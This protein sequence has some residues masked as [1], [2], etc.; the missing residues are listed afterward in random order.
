MRLSFFT[1]FILLVS[2]RSSAQVLEVCSVIP[3]SQPSTYR[4]QCIPSPNLTVANAGHGS[5]HGA[6]LAT[7][8]EGGFDFPFE[9]FNS[10]PLPSCLS[11]SG[12]DTNATV[13]PLSTASLAKLLVNSKVA[14][15]PT[16][17]HS[18]LVMA[19]G[20]EPL[21]RSDVIQ[22]NAQMA[23][24]L[25][26][27]PSSPVFSLELTVPHAASIPSLIER[28]RAIDPDLTVRLATRDGIVVTTAN[29]VQPACPKLTSFL[30]K[31]RD[32]AWSTHPES[33]EAR[34]P[35]LSAQTAAKVLGGSA[36][37]SASGDD[38][39]DPSEDKTPAKT[40]TAKPTKTA[41]ASP[42]PSAV[43]KSATTSKDKSAKIK[44]AA[45][46]GDV[47][48]APKKPDPGD[49][50]KAD[51]Q[52]KK[53]TDA[54][55]AAAATP[56]AATPTAVVTVG[57]IGSDLLLFTS[58]T[59]G[60]DAAIEE[61]KRIVAILNL[62]RPEM[63]ISAWSVQNSS[64]DE[65]SV[66]E[67]SRLVREDVGSYNSG[68]EK[69]LI[70][71][72]SR[73]R[74]DA[75]TTKFF[76]PSFYTYIADRV[77][78]EQGLDASPEALLREQTA[79]SSNIHKQDDERKRLGICA[80]NSYCLGYATL[81]KP[82]QPRLIDLLL[83]MIAAQSPGN[84]LR[85]SVNSAQNLPEDEISLVHTNPCSP[86]EETVSCHIWKQ[87][88]PVADSAPTVPVSTL[89]DPYPEASATINCE[90][91]DY[92][93]ILASIE[94]NEANPVPQLNCFRQTAA[95]LFHTSEL[96]ITRAAVADFLF[97][98]KLSQQYPHEFVPYDLTTSAQTMNTAL[99]PVI[100]SFVQD[101]GAYQAVLKRKLS[102]Q[103]ETMD[104]GLTRHNFLDKPRFF[105]NA[106][107]TVNTIAGD[108]AS[109]DTA[110]ESYLEEMNAPTLSALASAVAGTGST[111][112]SSGLSGLLSGARLNEFQAI[113]G[114]I[115][116]FQ[117]SHVH[118]GRELSIDVKPIALLGA[119]S[120]EL[121]VTLKADDTSNSGAY[122]DGGT[123]D[124]GVSRFSKSETAT[125]VRV[126]SLKLFEVSSFAS[127]LSTPK[128]KFPLVPPFVELPY[129]GS[130]LSLPL[131]PSREFHASIAVISAIVIP[132]SADLAF[133]AR[134]VSDRLLAADDTSTQSCLF[135]GLGSTKGTS[136]RTRT[137]LSLSDFAGRSPREYNRMK[138]HCLATGGKHA[139]AS[140]DG[141]A[142]GG[143]AIC[144][145]LTFDYV[146]ADIN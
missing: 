146:P 102:L 75:E 140:Y 17:E 4:L 22:L 21:A 113:A 74:Q 59:P 100:N 106:I 12:P 131:P 139:F 9:A 38:S 70:R 58:N 51:S 88:Y 83:V 73:L 81:F 39:S 122:S 31:A 136:C 143:S 37:S 61:K 121:Q 1:V 92:A 135:L 50:E 15:T 145:A 111:T 104:H 118:L 67:S 126:D 18:F 124:A 43:T 132:T 127:Q 87:L 108:E 16:S 2:F 93:D 20:D 54:K 82:L 120:A 40:G 77:V 3:A 138:I 33:P 142:D 117:T 130:I 48:E 19:D 53:V 28:L 8:P 41:G 109:V 25:G 60:D 11:L 65:R 47:S 23:M 36:V 95:A 114:G 63:S 34:L 128:K 91:L 133:T 129:L 7:G 86:S 62:P 107:V 26:A 79:S 32:L 5:N 49:A 80:A 24:L 68:L 97:N 90:A 29:G 64:A 78:F 76:Y 10:A 44:K 45:N 52:D 141:S 30:R 27:V 119:S 89:A 84:A 85:R 101:I 112:S 110:T 71:G 72:W 69:M 125:T 42:A 99:R 137:M 66:S 46:K 144:N 115:S 56:S 14:L 103:M 55:V 96:D 105:E 116:Q 35:S 134:F 94:N 57:S 13:P 123:G 98:Y 6:H